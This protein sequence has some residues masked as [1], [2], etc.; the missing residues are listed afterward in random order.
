MKAI[1]NMQK[2]TKDWPMLDPKTKTAASPL[3]PG[4]EDGGNGQVQ[5]GHE[6]SD[7]H[8]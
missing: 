8:H 7:G 4:Y 2:I 1:K 6:D 3:D 5:E